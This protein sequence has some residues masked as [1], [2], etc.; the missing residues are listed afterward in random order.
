MLPKA[1]KVMYLLNE[2]VFFADKA[3]TCT[4]VKPFQRL[5]GFHLFHIVNHLHLKKEMTK[6]SNSIKYCLEISNKEVY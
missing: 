4:D 3:Q 2:E 5:P 1:F 6:M